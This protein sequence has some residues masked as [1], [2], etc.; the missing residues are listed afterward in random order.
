MDKQTQ[1][2]L[3]VASVVVVVLFL[4]QPKNNVISKNSKYK[5]PKKI[6]QKENEQRKNAEV[7]MKAFRTAISK[8]ESEKELIKLNKE[9]FAS[10]GLKVYLESPKGKLYVENK[11]GDVILKES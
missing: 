1:N 10:Y 3:I 4:A 9:I 2:L 11:Q 8:N 7:S 6:S 5:E